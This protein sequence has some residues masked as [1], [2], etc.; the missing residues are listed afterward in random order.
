MSIKAHLKFLRLFQ[1]EQAYQAE[2][3]RRQWEGLSG[4][5]TARREAQRL[6]DDQQKRI[7]REYGLLSD[8]DEPTP[9]ELAKARLDAEEELASRKKIQAEFG[10]QGGNA[11]GQ[12]N[13]DRDANIRRE[14]EA[15]VQ[16]N[17]P[18]PV[19]KLA[20]RYELGERRI[21]QIVQIVKK[22]ER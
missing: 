21:R 1:E 6:F 10:R 15:M 14:H 9:A 17:H 5:A 19:Q 3:I 12:V 8:P 11:K 18:A 4:V 20:I 2:K 22:S 13:A 7:L 16:A